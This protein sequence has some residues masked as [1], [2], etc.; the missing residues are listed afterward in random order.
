MKSCPPVQD[1]A[2]GGG[3]EEAEAER[4]MEERL[5]SLH[6]LTLQAPRNK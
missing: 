6:I 3:C 5:A 2:R 1:Y 4:E